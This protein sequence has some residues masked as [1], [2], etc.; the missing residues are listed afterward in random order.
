MWELLHNWVT[1]VQQSQ[2]CNVIVME[3]DESKIFLSLL[4]LRESPV[5]LTGFAGSKI[6]LNSVT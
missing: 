5:Q 1:G 2:E 4:L 3:Q 6:M